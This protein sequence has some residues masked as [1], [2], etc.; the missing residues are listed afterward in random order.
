MGHEGHRNLVI[1]DII[2]LLG[3]FRQ[4]AVSLQG[5]GDGIPVGFGVKVIQLQTAA[6]A[7][8]ALFT[9]DNNIVIS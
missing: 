2:Q 1:T 3:D 8:D 7:G 5:I 6:G 9:V 4:V